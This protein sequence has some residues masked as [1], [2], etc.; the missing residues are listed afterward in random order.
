MNFLV[1]KF[2]ESSY[3]EIIKS[4][5]NKS[6]P[7]GVYGISDGI[8]THIAL[9]VKENFNSKV[10]IIAKDGLSA[11]RICED[12]NEISNGAEYLSS[13]E[14]FLYDRFFKGL[15]NMKTRVN[16]LNKLSN[17]DINY[18][19]LTL[20]G[21]RDK[22]SSKKDFLNHVIKIKLGDEI[23]ISTFVSNL[24][25]MGYERVDTVESVGEFSIRGSIID[26]Y[27]SQNPYRI[28][29]FDIEVDSIRSFTV[30]NQRSIETL[31]EIEI[32]P[33]TDFFVDKSEIKNIV[34]LIKKDLLKL[35]LEEKF[36]DRAYEKFSKYIDNLTVGNYIANADL[37]IPYAKNTTTVLDYLENPIVL[38]E[39][40]DRLVSKELD[41]EVEKKDYYA[42]LLSA[43][44]I[45]KSHENLRRDILDV[46]F[47]LN[48]L[49]VVFLNFLTTRAKY[50][51][52]KSIVNLKTKST[53]NYTG[54]FKLFLDDIRAYAINGYKT[55]IMAGTEDRANRIF[56]SLNGEIKTLRHEDN[57]DF[58]IKS[59]EVVICPL[60]Y[61]YG[62]EL[63][64]IKFVLINYGSIYSDRDK[65]TKYKKKKSL[66]FE[67]LNIGDYVVHE[68][69]GIG[70]YVGT[71]T[72]EIK[73]VKKD[74]ALI[75][76]SGTDKLFLPIENL[77]SIYKYVSSD[78]KVPKINKLNSIEW[79]KTKSKAKKNVEDVAEDLI[80]LYAKRQEKEGFAFSEDTPWQLE[81]EDAFEFEET[82]GQLR[83]IE[84]IKTDMQSHSPM[85]RL[86]CADVG[87]GKT[88]V[89]IRAAFK[90]IMDGKQVA[91][92][93]PTTILAQQ[94][95]NTFSER[96][97]DLGLLIIDEEQRFGVRHKE[98]LRM[99]KEN[100]DTLTLSA[101]PIPR[102]LQMSMIG[103]RDM[104]VIEE[105]PRERFPIQ[106]YV[107]EYNDMSIREA[108]LKE[109]E[110]DGQVFFV[111]NKVSNMD[112]KLL[113]LSKLVP[114][115][116]F[117]IAHGQMEEKELEDTMYEFINH[118]FDVLICSTIIETGMDI[119]NA[120]TMIITDS[121]KLGLSQL[122]QLRGRIGRSSRIAYAYFTYDKGMVLTEIAEKRLKAIREFTDFGSGYKIALRDLE[123]RGS[124]SLLGSR[125]HGHINMIGYDL[126]MKYLKDAVKKL[127]GEEVFEDVD[128]IVDLR[129]DS[130]IPIS[131]IKSEE[132]RIEIYKKIAMISNE[133][134]YSDLVDE[135]IDRFS[136]IPKEV[137]NLQDVALIRAY[138]KGKNILS[139]VEKSDEVEFK[140]KNLPSL[141]TINNIENTFRDVSFNLSNEPSIKVKNLKN[142][143][144]DI[145]KLISLIKI[146][147][148]LTTKI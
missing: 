44:E 128:T 77:D 98:K 23:D 28:E 55:L 78:G 38:I 135:L 122:Y 47:D 97:K 107:L 142:K 117:K 113:E 86:L 91:V 101:T 45:L 54:K 121:N 60:K 108:I 30:S 73:G 83:S 42:E 11:K 62:F 19:V 99:L 39:D 146:H 9:N 4:I 72:L 85:D 102:T 35:N 8:L 67:D 143:I 21:L 10:L 82:E 95:Y 79:N 59:S 2:K 106:T 112:N 12:L 31:D 41:L 140:L 93:V 109:I 120:N 66:N 27:S 115:A 137:S 136:D 147:K 130:Y 49:N 110:R 36:K 63:T 116:S 56:D 57:L 75:E 105:P 111:Y 61:G 43:G 132:T 48:N 119:Q 14:V 87:Y 25:E 92:L 84:E 6:T 33:I 17:G 141:E 89:A 71:K 69:N 22:I 37:I 74:Y 129:L 76:Y 64:D 70:K 13:R 90:A 3:L 16:V 1:D 51:K 40:P 94:H 15:D 52:P 26:I 50:F 123:I 80:K 126:Y 65:K 29:L 127:K 125:Q 134:E 133:E 104:S 24:I 46:V 53:T 96:F 139:I 124:G 7:V 114:E 103:I 145:K 148:N 18:L 68:L 81:F 138:A 144:K 88:E 58:Q 131:Y 5:E 100:V 20:D 34:N 118:K 32:L